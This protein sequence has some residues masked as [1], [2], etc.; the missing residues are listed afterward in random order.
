MIG[1]KICTFPRGLSNEHSRQVLD[2]SA[3]SEK[4]STVKPVYSRHLG[5]FDKMTTIDR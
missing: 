1:T 3:V 2:D 4:K 5:E